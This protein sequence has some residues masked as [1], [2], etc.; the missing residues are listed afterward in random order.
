MAIGSCRECDHQVSSEAKTCPSCGCTGPY[1]LCRECGHQV[2]GEAK[3]CPSCGCPS[4]HLKVWPDAAPDVVRQTEKEN[5]QISITKEN[6]NALK[7][8]VIC[9]AVLIPLSVVCGLAISPPEEIRADLVKMDEL[10]FEGSPVVISVISL[11]GLGSVLIVYWSLW[12]LYH[13][14]QNGFRKLFWAEV[15]GLF[16]SWGLGGIWVS[17]FD[18]V[19]TALL[20]LL[21]GAILYI[22]Y[23]SDAYSFSAAETNSNQ[24]DQISGQET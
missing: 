21:T 23:L 19:M 9:V 17:G 8:L 16:C 22:G 24:A 4:P 15:I 2:S 20:Y 6:Q 11:V 12:Q 7:S 13:L 10:A 5:Q 18:S 3:P 14:N 1:V